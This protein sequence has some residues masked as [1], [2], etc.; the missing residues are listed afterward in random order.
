MQAVERFP[1]SAEAL[2]AAA[3]A[4]SAGAE[5]VGA[6]GLVSLET[7]VPGLVPDSWIPITSNPV[8]NRERRIKRLRRT[9]WASGR[10]LKLTAP[11]DRVLFVT[12]TYDTKGTL[13]KGAHDWTPRHISEALKRYRRWCKARAIPVRYVWVAEL[14]QNGHMHYHVALWVPRHITMPKWDKAGPGRGPFWPHG[15][16]RTE[17]ARDAVGYLM[18]YM[19]KIGGY[20]EYP[21]GA[22]IYGVGGIET[23]LRSICSWLNLPEWVKALHGVGEVVTRAG[24][25]VVRETGEILVSPWR[26]VRHRLGLFLCRVSE[27]PARFADGPFSS[28]SVSHA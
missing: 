15:M 9:V 4:L 28:W 23:A 12:L 1:S 25:R 27:V 11:R 3:H 24:R 2:P 18:K 22:R 10:L 21:K 8:R 20:H 16:T 19:S 17:V 6:S 5:G 13:G 26:R 14:Q 7:S